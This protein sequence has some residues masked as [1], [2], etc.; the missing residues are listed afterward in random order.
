MEKINQLTQSILDISGQ[1]NLLALNASIEAAR[2]GEAG[3]G[4]AVVADEIGGLASQTSSTV[5]NING[6]T[7]EVNQ[8][9]EN[10]ES[11]LQEIL[12]FLEGTVL[13]DYSDFMGVAE[14]YTQVASVFEENM[15]AIGVEVE[16]L[17]SAIVE[18]ADSVNNITL[19]VSDAANNISNI[20]QKTLDVSQLVEG[21]AELMETNSENVVKLKNIVDMFH[22]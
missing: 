16:T 18:I 6:I 20:A 17:L 4:F 15:K 1:T 11:C 8:A 12:S 21:N 5:S 7:T 13:K 14:K 22:N 3:R 10:M 2:A 9:V 19:T